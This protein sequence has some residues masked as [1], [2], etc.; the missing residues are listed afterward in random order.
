MDRGQMLQE[1]VPSWLAL[2]D[3]DEVVIV[4]WSSRHPVRRTLAPIRDPRVNVV[5]VEGQRRW[6]ASKSHNLGIRVA[7]G[8]VLLRL[9]SDYVL[10]PTFMQEHA[11]PERAFFAGNW[12]RARTDNERHLTGALYIR[13][14][15][16]LGVNGYNERIV[17]YG[18]EDDDLFERLEAAGLTRRDI[19]LDTIQHLPHDDML[20]TR[21]QDVVN[22]HAETERNKALAHERPWSTADRLTEWARREDEDGLAVWTEVTGDGS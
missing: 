21:N 6:I 22:L 18:Y 1:A 16:L 19:D 3:I 10:E 13:K 17:T 4:D 7:S 2:P 14:Q 9:D 20:R 8:D 11:L 15:D 5:R 12:R